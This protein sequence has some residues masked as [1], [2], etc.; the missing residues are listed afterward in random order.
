MSIDIQTLVNEIESI[1]LAII[2]KDVLLLICITKLHYL[3]SNKIA[4]IT[5]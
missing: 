5:S 2:T 1:L 4:D 3:S